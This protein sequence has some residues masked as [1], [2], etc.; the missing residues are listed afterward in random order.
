MC[1]CVVCVCVQ[2]IHMCVCVKSGCIHVH[3][4]VHG[5]GGCVGAMCM[6]HV[7]MDTIWECT[8]MCT[9]RTTD[10]KREPAYTVITHTDLPAAC[11]FLHLSFCCSER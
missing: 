6:V 7:C 4:H 1:V 8:C 5:V 10:T 9:T 3:V 2:C 11:L